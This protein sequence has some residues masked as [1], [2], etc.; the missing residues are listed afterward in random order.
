MYI[1][2]SKFQNNVAIDRGGGVMV[3]G[4][5]GVTLH[6]SS[7][8]GNEGSSGGA[9]AMS[10]SSDVVLSQSFC[11]GNIASSLSGAAVHVEETALTLENNTFTLNE[12]LRGELVDLMLRTIH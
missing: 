7:F 12:A 6:N 5:V 10:E 2:H 4:S 8:V 11:Q 1:I 3:R 9:M